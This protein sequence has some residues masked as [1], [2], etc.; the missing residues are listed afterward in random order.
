MRVI[1]IVLAVV[2]LAFV[3]LMLLAPV[4]APS[5]T[6]TS[7]TQSD[8]A[9]NGPPGFA[10]ALGAV[11]SPFAPSVTPVASAGRCPAGNDW[12]LPASNAR[13]R[14][15][16]VQL[17]PNAVAGKLVFAPNDPRQDGGS[18]PYVLCLRADGSNLVLPGDCGSAEDI[19][20]KGSLPVGPH[21]GCLAWQ[22]FGTNPAPPHFE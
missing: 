4:Y 18:G 19:R 16:H 1:L 2:G 12:T 15:L 20:P 9:K 21:G 13:Y 6:Q 10:S 7:N 11:F 5:Q 3:A 22:G 17:A 14:V 8:I